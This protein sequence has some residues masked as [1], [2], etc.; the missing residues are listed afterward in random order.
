MHHNMNGMLAYVFAK[1]GGRFILNV[2]GNCVI[3]I[4]PWVANAKHIIFSLTLN[5]VIPTHTHTKMQ[6]HGQ[7]F[8][9]YTL[10]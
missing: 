1:C 8:S 5:Y 2:E 7:L 4:H 10:M 3:H 6:F 9:H